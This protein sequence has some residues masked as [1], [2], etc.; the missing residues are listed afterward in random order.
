MAGSLLKNLQ[1]FASLCGQK[2]MKNVVI[3]TTMWSEVKM[4]SG[5][6]REE[7]LKRDFW[8]VMLAGGCRTERFEDTYESAWS[9]VGQ[10]TRTTL[11]LQEEMGGVGKLLS[12]TNAYNAA[13][14][15]GLPNWLA[16]IWKR[17]VRN[18]KVVEDLKPLDDKKAADE[19]ING[20]ERARKLQVERQPSLEQKQK[21]E[22]AE[23]RT[24][25][26][27]KVTEKQPAE[28]VHSDR[29]ASAASKR[30]IDPR[31]YEEVSKETLEARRV[32]EIRQAEEKRLETERWNEEMRQKALEEKRR[33][34]KKRADEIERKKLED[35]K[36]RALR[37]KQLADERMAAKL[38]AQRLAEER[39]KEEEKL[40]I[41]ASRKA[42]MEA[43]IFEAQRKKI[44]EQKRD[45]VQRAAEVE[46]Q[47]AA[48]EEAL[49]KL[50]E[51]QRRLA[52]E[53][54]WKASEERRA[55]ENR[56]ANKSRAELG[57]QANGKVLESTHHGSGEGTR[58]T[59]VMSTTKGPWQL[60]VNPGDSHRGLDFVTLADST[61]QLFG[62][63]EL[64]QKQKQYVVL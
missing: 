7:E 3:A 29:E 30:D 1:M 6:R 54:E 34:D 63:I 27:L 20:E 59:E 24:Q 32:E 19:R 38:E 42:E 62:R 28:D 45:A 64:W 41:E 52:A 8:H 55:E 44:E 10:N 61:R 21:A 35:A 49:E 13:V 60:F 16:N 18:I 12:E 31:Q 5:V 46:A 50:L 43:S 40:R 33:E 4:E 25:E 47:R 9:I 36:G 14:K 37:E 53:L 2:A 51:N 22:E 57:K 23:R 26:S 17:V 56:R 39:A 15:K 48:E 11:L 58:K